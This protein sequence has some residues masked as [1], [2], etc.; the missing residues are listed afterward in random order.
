MLRVHVTLLVTQGQLFTREQK[1]SSAYQE[2]I[3]Y[4]NIIVK[5]RVLSH[6]LINS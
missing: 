6:D 1:P 3:Q 5:L 4:F 2:N